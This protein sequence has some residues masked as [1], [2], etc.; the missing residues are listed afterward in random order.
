MIRTT[1]DRLEVKLFADGRKLGVKYRPQTERTLYD[2]CDLN[3]RVIL[4]GGIYDENTDINVND[5][6]EDQYIILIL[7]G[8]KVCSKKFR[9]MR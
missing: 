5:L 4:T 3:G 7:D 2:I 8:D 6:N 1:F 9:I